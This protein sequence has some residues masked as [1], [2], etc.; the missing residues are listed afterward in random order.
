M[1]HSCPVGGC[2]VLLWCSAVVRRA[3]TLKMKNSG[4]DR[5]LTAIRY[6]APWP[7]RWFATK[8]RDQLA[9]RDPGREVGPSLLRA[10]TSGVLMGTIVW[11]HPDRDQ[12]G[13]GTVV[14]VALP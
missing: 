1:H 2:R 9:R 4:F 10:L 3:A 5:R 6:W 11:Q 7:V 13:R 12:L 8:A 14:L